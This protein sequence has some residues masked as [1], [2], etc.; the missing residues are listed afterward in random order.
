MKITAIVSA[1]SSANKVIRVDDSTYRIY[2]TTIPEKGKA[3]HQV[4]RLL[5]EYLKIAPSRLEIRFG[6]TSK[7]KIIE[8]LPAF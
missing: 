3:N 4:I 1:G 6:K 8:I 5:A 7:E 2:T